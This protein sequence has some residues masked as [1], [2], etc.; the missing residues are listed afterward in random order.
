MARFE[1]K[2]VVFWRTKMDHWVG[3]ES[4]KEAQEVQQDYAKVHGGLVFIAEVNSE[5]FHNGHEFVF[6][7]DYIKQSNDNCDCQGDECVKS[8]N[9]FKRCQHF[10][11]IIDPEYLRG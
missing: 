8:R 11:V 1:Y 6:T 10:D 4:L 5:C 7:E 2:Y 3:C 9:H